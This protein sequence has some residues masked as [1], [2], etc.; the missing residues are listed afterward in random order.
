MKRRD[1]LLTST[2][3]AGATLLGC[4]AASP[5]IEVSPVLN[6]RAFHTLRRFSETRFGKIAYVE[7][8]VGPVAIFF[9]GYPLNGFQWRGALERL[10]FARRCIAPDFMGLG[11]TETSIT[12]DLGPQAQ[13]DMLVAFLNRLSVDTVD[14]IASDSGGTIAQLFLVQ[15]PERVRTMLL[16][17]CD[18]HENSPPARLRPFIETARAGL[19]A[20]QWL[21]PQFADKTFARSAKGLGGIAYTDPANFTDEAIEY[22]YSP[23]LSSAVRKTQFNRYAVAF[24]PNPLLAIESDLKRC[25]A[26]A[27]MVWGT[28]D[29]LFDIAWAHWLDKT[30]RQSRGVRRVEGAKLFFPEEMPDLIAE[31]AMK[32]WGVHR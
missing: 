24:D 5:R 3:L 18:V 26:P 21:A 31:E 23:L 11:Y 1:F 19:A 9:H 20:D 8:G 16:T 29:L 15:N 13:A 32:L 14:L 22:Y 27:R 12:Q 7:R 25:D 10:S 4:K 6:A 28:A 30:L 17:N 2:G